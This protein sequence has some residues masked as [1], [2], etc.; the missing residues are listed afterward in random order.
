MDLTKAQRLLI[1]IQTFLDNGNGQHLSRL[2]KDLL[3][4]YIQQLY[5]VVVSGDT[6]TIE[7]HPNKV[8][9]PVVQKPKAEVPPVFEPEPPR[10]I[11]EPPPI[12]PVPPVVKEP[13]HVPLDIEEKVT[14][15]E[16]N[17]PMERKEEKVTL[18]EPEIPPVKLPRTETSVHAEAEDALAKLF[19]LPKQDDVSER[20]S[21]IPISNIESALGLNERIFTLNELFGGNRILFEETCA[22]LNQFTSF[23]EATTLLL[24][25]PAK[26]FNWADP[27]RIRMAE[28]F[29]RIVSRRYPKP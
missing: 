13:V 21:H 12:K 25:G 17:K 8:E 20:F 29:I 7:E 14:L 22:L 4:T 6:E 15:H 11:I 3:K 26:R 5:D 19:D 16:T 1:K 28:H 10:V 18:K 23:K 27:E 2:E 9:T 24:Y